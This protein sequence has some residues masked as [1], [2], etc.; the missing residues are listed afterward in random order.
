MTD[1]EKDLA[2][3]G[4]E[5]ATANIS[6]NTDTNTTSLLTKL[7]KAVTPIGIVRI[8]DTIFQISTTYPALVFYTVDLSVSFALLSSQAI[9]V[10]LLSDASSPPTTLHGQ[11]KLL[12]SQLLGLGVTITNTQRQQLVA[13]IPAGNYVKLSS[14]GTGSA[15][16]INS[17]ELLFNG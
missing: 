8:L 10:D 13:Y 2:I 17:L 5:V 11:A 3:H 16:L 7:P 6:D 4:I 15:T 9:T 1:F 12:G 14:S